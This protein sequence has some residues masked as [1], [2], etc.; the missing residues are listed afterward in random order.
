VV[1]IPVAE[2]LVAHRERRPCPSPMRNRP[3][4]VQICRAAWVATTGKWLPAGLSNC[5][6]AADR[7]QRRGQSQHRVY[8]YG[9][10][11][12][13]RSFGCFSAIH[14]EVSKRV[15]SQQSERIAL[16]AL[17]GCRHLL[18]Q[19]LFHVASGF[20]NTIRE[21]KQTCENAHVV[22]D[23]LPASPACVAAKRKMWQVGDEPY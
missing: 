9:A 13:T 8:R 12:I 23:L 5:S 2:A 6:T 16:Q 21:N 19:Y 18:V 22:A 17:R 14:F 4:H 20:A 15:P 10:L 3:W 7:I 11:R 1:A